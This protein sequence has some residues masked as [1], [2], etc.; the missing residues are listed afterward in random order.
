MIG[1]EP[2]LAPTFGLTPSSACQCWGASP[3]A[4][5]CPPFLNLGSVDPQGSVTPGVVRGRIGLS[6]LR[7]TTSSRSTSGLP[8]RLQITPPPQALS[9]PALSPTPGAS[10][11]AACRSCNQG[12]FPTCRDVTP[13]VLHLTYSAGLPVQN[14]QWPSE[15]MATRNGH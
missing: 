14:H 9:S 8:Q 4:L 10:P 15:E 1:K 13:R 3:R 6:Y 2:D 7:A 12:Y 5:I 11:V